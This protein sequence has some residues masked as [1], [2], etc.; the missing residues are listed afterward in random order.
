LSQQA[1]AQRCTVLLGRRVTPQ[2]L[3]NLEHGARVPS[4]PLLRALATVLA[5]EP[6]TVGAALLGVR[7]PETPMRP[8]SDTPPSQDL[9][10]HVRD[11]VLHTTEGYR[12]ASW[13]P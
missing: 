11:A 12:C 13:P 1:L 2:Y 5:L 6:A 8:L 4:V 9:L 10:A 3:S 7:P